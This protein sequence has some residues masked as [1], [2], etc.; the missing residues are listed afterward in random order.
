V[1]PHG[2]VVVAGTPYLAGSGVFTDACVAHVL[3]LADVSL[4]DAIDMASARPRE[5]L[6]LEPRTVQPGSPADLILFD[7]QPGKAF[8]IKA[9][10]I[11][12]RVVGG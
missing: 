10:I 7:W 12:G 4:S 11:A 1:L 5:L 8:D 3:Q 9:T 6:R 2:R